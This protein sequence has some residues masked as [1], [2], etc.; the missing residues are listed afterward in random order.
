MPRWT[1]AYIDELEDRFDLI[2][3]GL[4]DRLDAVRTG[5][6][7]PALEDMA[8]GSARQVNASVLFFDICG[9]TR[10]TAADDT[11]ALLDTLYMLDCVIPM[12]MHVVFDHGGYVEKNTGDGV[13]AIV[14]V[15]DEAET[16]TS[17]A[18]DIAVVSL[19]AIDKIVNPHL[20]ARGIDPVRTS[21]GIDYGKLLLARIGTRRGTAKHDRSHVTAVGPTANIAFQLQEFA[22]AD[23]IV[24]GGLVYLRSDRPGDAFEYVSP[25]D[26]PWTLGG[27]HYAAWR[28]TRRRKDPTI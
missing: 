22:G 9:F 18:I 7:A 24:V 2:I 14:G 27:K 21:F 8:I 13:M 6:S 3:D 15:G 23:Q 16:A 17:R 12:V 1:Q 19:F 4:D 25:P 28:Y 11:D 20:R 26:W 5:T 10:R